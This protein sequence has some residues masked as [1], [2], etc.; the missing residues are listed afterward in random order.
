[1]PYLFSVYN[2]HLCDRTP[3][4]FSVSAVLMESMP[5]HEQ[6]LLLWYAGDTEYCTTINV[7]FLWNHKNL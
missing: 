6:L 3:Y 7:T 2:L 1:M 4:M 5:R